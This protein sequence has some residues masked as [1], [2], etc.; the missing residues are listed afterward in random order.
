MAFTPF[1]ELLDLLF[2]VSMWVPQ[3]DKVFDGH[4]VALVAYEEDAHKPGGGVFW[5]RDSNGPS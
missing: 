1:L 2:P 5:F 3:R 4:G